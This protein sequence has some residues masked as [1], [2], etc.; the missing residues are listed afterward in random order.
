MRYSSF[1]PNL[2]RLSI[3]RSFLGLCLFALALALTPCAGFAQTSNTPAESAT[4]PQG[5]TPAPTTQE[6][7]PAPAPD[8]SKIPTLIPMSNDPPEAEEVMVPAKPV[9]ILSGESSWDDSIVNLKNAFTQIEE[10]LTKAGK[11]PAG[12]PLAVFTKTTDDGFSFDAMI[13][14]SEAPAADQ[15]PLAPNIRFGEVPPGKALRFVHR[16]PYE[17]ISMT[18]EG[19][20]LYLESKDLVSKDAFIEEYVTDITDQ[21]DRGLV[22]NIYVELKDKE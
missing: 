4:S 6:T 18:Y 17:Q 14:V 2:G 22:V 16:E 3:D 9:A 10:A 5:E 1:L 21:S 8:L 12:R 15:P 19:V 13:P 11:K 20:A 7:P